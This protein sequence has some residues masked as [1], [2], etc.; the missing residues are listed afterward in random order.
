M[1]IEDQ[2]KLISQNYWDLLDK[3]YMIIQII[4]RGAYG[5]VAEAYDKALKRKVAVKM[6][7]N[8]FVSRTDCKRV[9]REI[10]LLR[11]VIFKTTY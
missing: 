9:L 4:G 11:K 6:I 10:H 2:Q 8:L 3:N 7:N 5:A 1:E